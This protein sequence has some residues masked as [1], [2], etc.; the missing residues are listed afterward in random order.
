MSDIVTTPSDANLH[1][2]GVLKVGGRTYAV[3]MTWELVQDTTKIQS[4]ARQQCNDSGNNLWVFLSEGSPQLGLG[5]TKQGHR[6]GMA[7]LA[8][9]LA[10]VIHGS[11]AGIFEADGAF[12]VVAARNGTI[13]K[14]SDVAMEAFDGALQ[15][16]REV[17][18]LGATRLYASPDLVERMPGLTVEPM[19]AWAKLP[20]P[21]NRLRRASAM[22]GVIGLVRPVAYASLAAVA[23]VYFFPDQWTQF[24]QMVGL[25]PPPKKQ[26]IV[27][28]PMPWTGQPKAHE[29]LANCMA[30]LEVVPRDAGG[31]RGTKATCDARNL[32]LTVVRSGSV[33]ENAPTINWLDG[34]KDSQ[35]VLRDAN[36]RSLGKPRIGA[37]G[38]STAD[39]VW[40]LPVPPKAGRWMDADRDDKVNLDELQKAMWR[41]AEG[42]FLKSS[43][44]T[45]SNTEYARSVQAKVESDASAI[46]Q[47]KPS[48]DRKLAVLKSVVFD[49]DHDYVFV[50]TRFH[51]SS[52]LPVNG[53]DVEVQRQPD[54]ASLESGPLPPPEN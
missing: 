13:E 54:P 3:A 29:A 17:A 40:S 44:A 48:L 5:S 21:T 39:I 15:V 10:S 18:A 7:A 20:K 23:V 14:A 2:R 37:V 41:T 38:A 24:K 35:D 27:I 49:L 43:F 46:L 12:Y 33:T 36:G 25:E 9:E 19:D 26:V 30:A 32:V 50:D 22:G 47:M 6:A 8:P 1:S 42:F 51:R 11:W 4:H 31:W 28:P 16:F 52:P 34:W 45:G 53:D